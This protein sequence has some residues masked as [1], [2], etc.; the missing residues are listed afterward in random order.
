MGTVEIV[1]AT[2]IEIYRQTHIHTRVCM[3]VIVCVY[4]C[5]CGNNCVL[6]FYFS[7]LGLIFL[8][9][10]VRQKPGF[11]L[12]IVSFLYLDYPLLEYVTNLFFLSF[13]SNFTG[14]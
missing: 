14:N 7:I 10:S 3:C 5:L 12:I 1:S 8:G 9:R 6:I 2:E 4:V 11:V 13:F